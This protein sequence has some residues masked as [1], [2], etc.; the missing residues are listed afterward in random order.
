[1]NA[2]Y[3]TDDEIF[4]AAKIVTPTEAADNKI[5]AVFLALIA[6]VAQ[7]AG[8]PFHIVRWPDGVTVLVHADPADEAPWRALLVRAYRAALAGVRG[9]VSMEA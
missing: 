6:N 4:A 1:M 5:E 7:R 8:S 9:P 3:L 2:A